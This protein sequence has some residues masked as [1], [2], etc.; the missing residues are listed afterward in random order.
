M[1]FEIFFEEM[2][3][4]ALLC[5]LSLHSPIDMMT[6]QINTTFRKITL[7]SCLSN[8]VYTSAPIY[9]SG[10]SSRRNG[11]VYSALRMGE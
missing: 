4:K 1:E 8:S 5:V 7:A 2:C 6:E 9:D 11:S 10:H 3:K